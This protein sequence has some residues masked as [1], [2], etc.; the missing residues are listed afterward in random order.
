MTELTRNSDYFALTFKMVVEHIHGIAMA[1][2]P[3]RHHAETALGILF[4][5]VRKAPLLFVEAAWINGLLNTAAQIGMGD[6][7][8]TVLLRLSARRKEEEAAP[9]VETHVQGDVTD[10]P[11]RGQTE[12]LETLLEY[13]LLSKIM[14]NIRTCIEEEGG[15]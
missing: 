12:P 9:D 10:L 2:G 4:T 11:S 14:D 5:L 15:W 8:F 1:R 13:V 7:T 3:R 6:G